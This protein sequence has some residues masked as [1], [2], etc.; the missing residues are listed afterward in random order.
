MSSSPGNTLKETAII[1]LV[2]RAQAA[3]EPAP[4][5]PA[6][7]IARVLDGA[8]PEAAVVEL[9]P[10]DPVPGTRYVIE[11][12]L[13]DGGMGVV[14]EARHLDI[15][16]RVALKVLRHEF[17]RRPAVTKLFR[18]EARIV[19]RIGSEH[20]VEVSDF[21]ELPDGR[22][23]FV[24]E[25]LRG[26]TVARELQQGPMDP[27]RVIAIMRQVCK[28]LTVAHASSVVHRDLKPDNIA[29]VEHRGRLDFAKVLDF[30]I[31][32]VMSEA[33][34]ATHAAAGT[35][36]YLAPEVIL[37]QPFDAR[38]DIYA[39]GCTAYEMLCG[40][41][42]FVGDGVEPVLRGHLETVP[43]P[44]SE[45]RPEIPLPLSRVVMRC[46]AKRADERFPSMIELEAALCQAQ[47]D[48]K[49]QT[50]W[51]D[52]PIPE[53]EPE[54]RVALLRQMPDLQGRAAS[55]RARKWWLAGIAAAL[56]LGSGVAFALGR[57]PS[58]AQDR[59]PIEA[60]ARAAYEAAARSYFVYPPPDS[61]EV[62]TAFA[63]VVELE[64]RAA[65]LGSDARTEA[66][67][68]REE[69][70]STLVRLGD[71][72]WDREGGKPFAIDY[73]AEA[74]VFEPGHEHA[75]SRAILT[76]GQLAVLREKAE[77]GSFS[78]AE[79]IA[80]EP[81]IA[82]AEPDPAQRSEKIAALSVRAR[83]S[84]TDESLA[85]LAPSTRARAP[86]SDVAAS[87]PTVVAA[88]AEPPPS[89]ADPQPATAQPE[90]STEPPAD[91]RTRDPAEA[92]QLVAAG[93]RARDSGR[94]ADARKAFERALALDPRS[95]AALIG[96]SDVAFHGGDQARA[97]NYARKAI[98]LAPRIADY[99]IRLGDAYFKAFRYEDARAEYVEAQRLGHASALARIAKVDARVK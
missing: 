85:K 31:A 16:R 71:D 87:T 18:D 37:G 35:P 33:D 42:P 2:A 34:A 32:S 77:T 23:L 40:H 17:C 65:E 52:L 90:T 26:G 7:W 60:L 99:R 86:K 25:L 1:P 67:R 8:E 41:P 73:Y 43:V 91:A 76:P 22:L 97:A 29:L 12:W 13:G 44:P 9:R 98:K 88:Q 4:P 6:P 79:L 69:F 27:A 62:A 51:D 11:R 5:G 75:A 36:S 54:R 81:L 92:A 74:L 14:Y 78:E 95:H 70:A 10:G 47:I 63:I 21:A 38:V 55:P 56:L 83:A 48:A 53:V 82:L 39:A 64:S 94:L 45:R 50:S 68:L 30:G 96:L 66:R 24:M 20:I 93:N 80:A 3:S 28:A 89:A 46:L 84:T 72:Y 59:G 61:P 58:V 49:L 15:D 57:E 19:S